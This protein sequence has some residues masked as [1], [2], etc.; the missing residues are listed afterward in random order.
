VFI[1]RTSARATNASA[2]LARHGLRIKF[3]QTSINELHGHLLANALQN[4]AT[5]SINTG[6]L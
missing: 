3:E 2:T 1:D 4:Q 6:H 5:R